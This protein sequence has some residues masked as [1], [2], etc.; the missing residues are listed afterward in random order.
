MTVAPRALKP[1]LLGWKPLDWQVR[2]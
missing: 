2:R 1:D